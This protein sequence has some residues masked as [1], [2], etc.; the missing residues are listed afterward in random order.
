MTSRRLII[1]RNLRDYRKLIAEKLRKR[2][3]EEE[4]KCK[5][6]ERD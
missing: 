2:N 5:S 3:A 4:K 6:L 1:K